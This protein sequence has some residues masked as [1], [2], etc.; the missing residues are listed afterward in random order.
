[1]SNNVLELR[2]RRVNGPD[3]PTLFA[4]AMHGQAST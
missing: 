2:R 1:M 4:P 3:D